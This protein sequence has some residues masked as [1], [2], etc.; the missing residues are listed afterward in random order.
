[1]L[2]TF[3]P[4]CQHQCLPPLPPHS[5]P[6]SLPRGHAAPIPPSL[7]VTRYSFLDARGVGALEGLRLGTVYQQVRA[8]CVC[9]LV[10]VPSGCL[11]VCRKVSCTTHR[12]TKLHSTCTNNHE[13]RCLPLCIPPVCQPPEAP[14]PRCGTAT[15]STPTTTPPRAM[16]AHPL[17]VRLTC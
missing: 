15:P 7:S 1:M 3:I 10:C 11:C 17:R 4:S 5:L 6:H 2:R 8:G 16:T 13:A 12:S 9:V 14:P